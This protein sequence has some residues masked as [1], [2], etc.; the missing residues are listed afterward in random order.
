MPWC[1][2]EFSVPACEL[3]GVCVCAPDLRVCVC[4]PGMQW[5]AAGNFSFSLPCEEKVLSSVMGG[6]DEPHVLPA[7]APSSTGGRASSSS[8]SGPPLSSQPSGMPSVVSL[9]VGLAVSKLDHKALVDVFGKVR[10]LTPSHHHAPLPVNISP[11][12]RHQ[13]S[14]LHYHT[15]AFYQ[16]GTLLVAPLTPATP[17]P[18]LLLHQGRIYKSF[19]TGG[20]GRVSAMAIAFDPTSQTAYCTCMWVTSGS[21]FK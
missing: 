15:I 17:P 20:E 13:A 10:A 9:P 18:P 5:G 19:L 2:C 16:S 8:S 11:G 1:V 3:V 4:L 6:R 21:S 14:L 7:P 12:I